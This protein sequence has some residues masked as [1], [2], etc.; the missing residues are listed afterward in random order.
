MQLKILRENPFIV[1][2]WARSVPGLCPRVGPFKITLQA[3]P[4]A[5]EIWK[6]HLT[7]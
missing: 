5:P 4:S 3:P 6:P 7:Q 2:G 1:R